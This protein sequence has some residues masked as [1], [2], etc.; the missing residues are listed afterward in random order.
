MHVPA[1]AVLVLVEVYERSSIRT[2]IHTQYYPATN[3]RNQALINLT[4]AFS[5]STIDDDKTT[6]FWSESCSMTWKVR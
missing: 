3:R 1:A 5:M 2:Y 4:V 6:T